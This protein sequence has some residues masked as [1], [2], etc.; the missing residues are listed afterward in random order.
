MSNQSL[1]MKLKIVS[2]KT[3]K[4]FFFVL[5]ATLQSVCCCDK[6]IVATDVKQ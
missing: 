2:N 4:V 1:Y 6:N 5:H 3:G